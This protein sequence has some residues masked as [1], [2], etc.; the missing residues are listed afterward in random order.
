MET[1]EPRL[2]AGEEI[3]RRQPP[4]LKDEDYCPKV[5]P[6][7][8]DLTPHNIQ[9]YRQYQYFKSIDEW[10]DDIW[11]KRWRSI[12]GEIESRLE[13]QDRDSLMVKRLANLLRR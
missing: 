5:K 13:Q 7:H 9:V 11:S 6:G 12:I 3:A 2:H 1:G 10:P 4:C 8:S